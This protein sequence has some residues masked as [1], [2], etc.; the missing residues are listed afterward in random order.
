MFTPTTNPQSPIGMA[1]HRAPSVSISRIRVTSIW[2][3]MWKFFGVRAQFNRI[4]SFFY[5]FCFSIFLCFF[6][7]IFMP[8][9]L[10]YVHLL[11]NVLTVGYGSLVFACELVNVISATCKP[12]IHST[13]NWHDHKIM[14]NYWNVI[15]TILLFPSW[16]CEVCVCV[17]L[18]Y[19]V[20]VIRQP[21]HQHIFLLFCSFSF[22]FFFLTRLKI[23]RDPL[24]LGYVNFTLWSRPKYVYGSG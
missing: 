5:V 14:A 9:P 18:I 16:W 7:L 6:F 11:F 3:M 13:R 8:F 1:A 23:W 19:D 22:S 20:V 10:F 17:A 15:V 4:R 12:S 21:H 2:L 24:R